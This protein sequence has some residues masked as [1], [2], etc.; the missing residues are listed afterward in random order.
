VPAH[1][2]S[3][4]E[5]IRIKARPAKEPELIGS[6]ALPGPLEAARIGN[7]DAL[8]MGPGEWLL[9]AAPDV[10]IELDEWE[11][12]LSARHVAAA[13]CGNALVIFK[14]DAGAAT[15]ARLSGLP[16]Q[17]LEHRRVARTRLADIPVTLFGGAEHSIWLIFDRTYAPHL[18]AWLDHAA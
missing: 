7:I 12:K 9:L 15:F 14:F 2:I 18:Q 16:V 13:R 5:A 4:Y 1:T 17:A 3:G 11:G 6:L 10:Q 8:W